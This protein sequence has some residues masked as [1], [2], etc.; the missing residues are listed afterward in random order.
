LGTPTFTEF[1]VPTANSAPVD[2]VA[3]PDGALWFSEGLGNKIGRVTTSGVITEYPLPTGNSVPNSIALGP[4]GALWFTEF[5][6]IT[7]TSGIG[8]ITTSGT[9]IGYPLSGIYP[10][11]IAAGPDGALWFTEHGYSI[12]R[13][14]TK[15]NVTEF[16]V[17]TRGFPVSITGGPD[18]GLW[19][20]ESLGT[21]SV[22]HG[23]IVHMTTAGQLSEIP[24]DENPF[25][26][27]VGPDGAIWYTGE[28]RG[29]G[30]VDPISG[31]VTNYG[32]L[33]P[34]VF[35]PPRAITAGPDGAL[36]FTQSDTIGR[37]VTT[38]QQLTGYPSPS[39]N[40]VLGGIASGPDCTIWFTEQAV[41]KIGRLTIG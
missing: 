10:Q 36:W 27:T 29:V 15:G 35:F 2:I 18:G 39:S 9:V 37:M 14:T 23:G 12:G 4:D 11:N 3:G 28:G 20:T 38:G 13:I 19:F 34:S 1:A 41:N 16:P 21:G 25:G 33:N 6:A 24:L 40:V 31:V 17:S 7:G 26:I 32:M 22:G 8:R 5:N 30:R